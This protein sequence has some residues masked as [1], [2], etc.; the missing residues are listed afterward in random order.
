MFFSSLADVVVYAE[1]NVAGTKFM[2]ML[3]AFYV[4]PFA[5]AAAGAPVSLS[6]HCVTLRCM[7]V[8]AQCGR[9]AMQIERSA[10][11]LQHTHVHSH[12]FMG[13]KGTTVSRCLVL[14]LHV[15]RK[16]YSSHNKFPI[17]N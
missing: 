1:T 2:H 7:L 12:V 9:V 13:V 3:I 17:H 11:S 10:P 14:V 8:A 4:Q 16:L 6:F 5:A 15:S